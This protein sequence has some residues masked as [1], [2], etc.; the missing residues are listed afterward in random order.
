MIY[1]ILLLSYFLIIRIIDYIIY[2]D[3]DFLVVIAV[4]IGIIS[5]YLLLSYVKCLQDYNDKHKPPF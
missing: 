4:I 3:A 1:D 2:I 5:I